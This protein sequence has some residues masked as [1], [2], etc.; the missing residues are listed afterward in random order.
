MSIRVL[1]VAPLADASRR[2]RAGFRARSMPAEGPMAKRYC[3]GLAGGHEGPVL[4]SAVPP[5]TVNNSPVTMNHFHP[6]DEDFVVF[7]L[8]SGMKT[9]ILRLVAFY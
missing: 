9:L 7:K 1:Y 5:N 2:V 3:R 6:G 8:E 4:P